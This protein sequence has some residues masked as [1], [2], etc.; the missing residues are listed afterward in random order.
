MVEYLLSLRKALASIPSTT[1][2][3]DGERTEKAERERADK[4]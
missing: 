3:R 1:R 4:S 2:D